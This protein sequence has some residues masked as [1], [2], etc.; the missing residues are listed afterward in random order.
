[1][2]TMMWMSSREAGKSEGMRHQGT[3]TRGVYRVLFWPHK[4]NHAPLGDKNNVE[5]ILM[6]MSAEALVFVPTYLHL[7]YRHQRVGNS[8]PQT[9]IQL[10]TM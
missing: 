8:G 4:S 1:M 10:E 7:R 3:Q 9:R 6:L 2:L 5:G